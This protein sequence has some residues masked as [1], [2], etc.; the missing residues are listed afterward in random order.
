M[1]HLDRDERR[2]AQEADRLLM[3]YYRQNYWGDNWGPFGHPDRTVEAIRKHVELGIADT[4]IVRL[5]SFD[6]QGQLDIFLNE[7]VPALQ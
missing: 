3:E 4:I 5:A 6:Q 7:V 1:R 2:A